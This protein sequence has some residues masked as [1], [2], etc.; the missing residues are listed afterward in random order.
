MRSTWLLTRYLVQDKLLQITFQSIEVN[1]NG[2]CLHWRYIDYQ[3]LLAD[4]RILRILV[5]SLPW[6]WQHHVLARR[7]LAIPTPIC[8]QS[9]RAP[10]AGLRIGDMCAGGR[11]S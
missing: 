10:L 1:T 4:L 7:H 9:Y 6:K 2:I 3:S 8:S 11:G 5:P